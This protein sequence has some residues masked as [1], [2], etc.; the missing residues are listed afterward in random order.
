[1]RLALPWIAAGLL[2]SLTAPAY[3][4]QFDYGTPEI[5]SP[6]NTQRGQMYFRMSHRYNA[7]E[8][9]SDSAPTVNLG[10]GLTKKTTVDFIA[11]TRNRPL[12]GELSLRYQFLD[13][14]DDAP[15]A[16]TTRLGYTTHI[17]GSAIGEVTASKNDLLPGLGLGLVGR[18]FS[19]VGD[20]A[21]NPGWM[22]AG[23][24]GLSYAIGEGFNLIGDIVAPLDSTVIDA[25][26]FN[27][28]AGFQWWIPDT[29]HVMLVF[30]GRMG[31]GSTY[32]RTFSP[33]KD[34]LRVG[35]EYHAHFD[36][37]FFPRRQLTINLEEDE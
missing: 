2:V 9:P 6:L 15:F 1:L 34:T 24:A 32:G 8:F 37:P 36:A 35:F 33:G 14:Y 16:L 19:Y 20:Y 3:A 29:P 5:S 27:W 25:M 31:P 17:G 30:V 13:E 22:T 21:A 23:G 26:G 10:V 7:M 11:S 12:D 18:Y 4:Y 28:S